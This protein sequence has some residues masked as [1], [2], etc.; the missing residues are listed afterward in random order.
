MIRLAKTRIKNDEKEGQIRDAIVKFEAIKEKPPLTDSYMMV[1]GLEIVAAAAW[2]NSRSTDKEAR[3]WG[4]YSEAHEATSQVASRIATIREKAE[5]AAFEY[6]LVLKDPTVDPMGTK[7]VNY[8]AAIEKIPKNYFSNLSARLSLLTMGLPILFGFAS[9]T[10]GMYN[11]YDTTKMSAGLALVTFIG[12]VIGGYFMHNKLATKAVE[13]KIKSVILEK[14][15][16]ERY[17]ELEGEI[18]DAKREYDTQFRMLSA[19]FDEL[20]EGSKM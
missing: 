5:V 16:E 19:Q 2:H 10:Y 9:S 8:R 14:D 12:A 4:V 18:A 20:R 1:Q 7:L 15:P 11:Y 13:Q 3:L 17:T 6:K